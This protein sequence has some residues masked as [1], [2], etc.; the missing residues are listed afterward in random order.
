MLFCVSA[1]VHIA[2]AISPAVAA[3]AVHSQPGFFFVH[4][5]PQALQHPC[6]LCHAVSTPLDG[7]FTVF[8]GT[9]Y[10]WFCLILFWIGFFSL[11]LQPWWQSRYLLFEDRSFY[12]FSTVACQ[13]CG[14]PCS[15]SIVR[16][17]KKLHVQLMHSVQKRISVR[18]VSS[19]LLPLRNEHVLLY[20]LRGRCYVSLITL[21]ASYPYCFSL[22]STALQVHNLELQA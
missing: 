22:Y 11:L 5:S 20:C 7:A 9:C 17:G 13:F 18:C 14:V 8:L 21:V 1:R 12:Q 6:W 4:D 16:F 3:R 10:C 19:Q 2:P 15:I